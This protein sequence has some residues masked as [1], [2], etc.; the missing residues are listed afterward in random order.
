MRDCIRQFLLP[1]GR[2]PLGRIRG[3]ALPQG[4]CHRM[5]R[6]VVQRPARKR[7]FGRPPAAQALKRIGRQGNAPARGVWK[8]RGQV[9]LDKFQGIK[10]AHGLFHR[11]RH[12]GA[13]ECK[14]AA[15]NG[16]RMGHVGEVYLRIRAQEHSELAGVSIQGGVTAC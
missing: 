10:L 9:R 12:Q 1:L 11:R 15:C 7:T 4:A 3:I 16:Q 6:V 14:T 8:G 13:S 2:A 5:V